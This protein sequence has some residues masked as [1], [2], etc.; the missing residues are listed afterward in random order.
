MA[1]PF[2]LLYRDYDDA[3]GGLR[4][5]F[6]VEMLQR[7]SIELHYLKTTRG[8][9]TPDYLVEHNDKRLVIE[10]G[11]PGKGHNQFK[12]VQ[13][14]LKL[15]LSHTDVATEKSVPLFLA[16]FLAPWGVRRNSSWC[17]WIMRRGARTKVRRPTERDGVSR[18]HHHGDWS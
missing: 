10:I 18:R 6:F 12:G 1:P 11:G 13:T 17:S 16:G 8:A 2:R 14:D 5:D 3:I 15:V 9:K 7:S 4:E